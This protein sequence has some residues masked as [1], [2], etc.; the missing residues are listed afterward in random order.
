MR[1]SEGCMTSGRDD[2]KIWVLN[3]GQ[4]RWPKG[5]LVTQETDFGMLYTMAETHLGGESI[6]KKRLLKVQRHQ[7]P[8]KDQTCNTTGFSHAMWHLWLGPAAQGAQTAADTEKEAVVRERQYW[9]LQVCTWR[10]WGHPSFLLGSRYTVFTSSKCSAY[11]PPMLSES[12]ILTP[13]G[14]A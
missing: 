8:G 7:P 6:S 4:M 1:P 3:H 2:V 11:R 13:G 14:H 9:E 10:Q 5:S 12:Q